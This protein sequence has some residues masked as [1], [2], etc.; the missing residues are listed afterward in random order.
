MLHRSLHTLALGAVWT[1]AELSGRLRAQL[2]GLAN[3][4]QSPLPA[5]AACQQLLADA[6]NDAHPHRFRQ[7]DCAEVAAQLWGE[8]MLHT[9]DIPVLDELFQQL[10]LEEL[11]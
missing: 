11:L 6:I 5:P 4:Q 9:P 3:C 8:Q 2:T 7:N 1:S 10:L